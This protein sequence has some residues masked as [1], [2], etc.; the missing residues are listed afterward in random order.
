MSGPEDHDDVEEAGALERRAELP[1]VQDDLDD[2]A[3]A[4]VSQL[5]WWWSAPLP[6]PPQ[7]A[8]YNEILPGLAERIVSMTEREMAHRHRMDR[9]FVHY[10]FSGQWVSAVVALGAM[11]AGSY[12]VS[13]G[14]TGYGFAAIISAVAGLVGVFLVRQFFGNGSSND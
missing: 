5:S 6:P 3:G 10:R 7:L 12:L 11:G 4:S 1:D 14:H 2:A 13:A 9:S 8:H